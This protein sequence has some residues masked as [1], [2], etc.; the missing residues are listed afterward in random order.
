MMKRLPVGSKP[1]VDEAAWAVALRYGEFGYG[2]LAADAGIGMDRAARL[3]AKWVALGLCEVSREARGGVRKL[4]RVLPDAT[5]PAPR[6]RTVPENLWASMRGLKSFTPTDLAAHS[7]TPEVP[8]TRA[9]AQ[10]Y[11]QVLLRA[12][13]LRVER[14][15]V[16]G[17]RDAIYRL[18]R[19]TGP[20]PPRERRVRAVWDDNLREY[21][22]IGGAA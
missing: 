22:H 15:A 7:S 13:Y 10:S 3:A 21:T 4:F 12:G 18:I 2:E 9:A 19:A 1:A 14:T 11:C 5:V 16:P 20:R 6:R 8:V 17:R